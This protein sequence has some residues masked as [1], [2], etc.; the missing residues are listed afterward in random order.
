MKVNTFKSI[1]LLMYKSNEN[2]PINDIIMDEGNTKL[3]STTAI[4]SMSSAAD[5]ASLKLGLCKAAKQGARC[6]ARKAEILY[7]LVLPCRKRQS[8]YWDRITAEE[9]TYQF[10]LLNACKLKPFNALRFN[11][12]GDFKSQACIDKAEKIARVLK[13]YGITAYC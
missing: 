12:S 3:S 1:A 2:N 13:T 4:F 5:C 11:E 10:L 9:F 7:P 6:Y 8:Q